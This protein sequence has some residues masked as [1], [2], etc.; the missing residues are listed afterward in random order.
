M[1]R[2][3]GVAHSSVDRWAEESAESASPPD[4]DESRSSELA[5]A[6]QMARRLVSFVVRLD[7]SR[8]LLDYIAPSRMG[9]HLARA[10][11]E[12]LGEDALGHAERLE[13]WINATVSTLRNG[14]Q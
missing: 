11:E 2:L 7:E 6:D 13:K 10:F 3:I 1:A 12:R 8:G 4:G 14:G 9:R 5:T